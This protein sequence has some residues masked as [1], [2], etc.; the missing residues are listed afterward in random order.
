MAERIAII[1]GGQSAEHEISIRSARS[2]IN[3]LDEKNGRLSLL[4]F[5]QAVSGSMNRT[6]PAYSLH[7]T[8]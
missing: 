2:V 7:K 8:N 3:A 5:Q 6:P 4:L 1:F